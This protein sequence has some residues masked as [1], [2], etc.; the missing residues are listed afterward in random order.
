[1]K[2]LRNLR[3]YWR[4]RRQTGRWGS[5]PPDAVSLYRQL[6]PWLR[7]LRAEVTPLSLGLP[8]ITFSAI[9]RIEAHLRPGMKVF[10]FGSGGSTLFFARRGAQV[11]SVEHDQAWHVRVTESL[12]AQHLS[13][14]GVR[15]VPPE[16]AVASPGD[17]SDPAAYVSSDE[18]WLQHSFHAYVTSIDLYAPDTFDVI[19]VDG[20]ARPACLRHALCR[21]KPGG[22]LLLD[23]SERPHYAP[24]MALADQLA[25]SRTDCSG[26]G[27]C[28]RYFWRTT[29]WQRPVGSASRTS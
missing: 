3:A 5:P 1:M 23:N 11:A 17:P 9:E 20:R 16:P 10:E 13:V 2:I 14:E 24:A 22:L 21:L 8:W 27:L 15:F 7:G 26:P 6:R 28:N 18:I 4:G 29:I 25:W 19:L 12:V